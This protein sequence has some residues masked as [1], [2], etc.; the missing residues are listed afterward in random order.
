MV[1]TADP[2]L[3]AMLDA[4]WPAQDVCWQAFERASRAMEELYAEP[5]DLLLVDECLPD[6][7]GLELAMAVKSENVYRQMPVVL[8]LRGPEALDSLDWSAMEVDEFLLRPFSPVEIRSRLALALARAT[9]TLDANP[10]SKLPGN[11]S[12]IQRVQHLVEAGAE[13]GLAY[14]DLDNFKSFNDKYGFSRGD[15]ALMMTA[16]LLV[17]V[18]REHPQQAPAMH[19]VGHVGGDDFVFI[20]PATQVEAACRAVC[21]RFDAIVPS[22]Y[23]E[24]D[25]R[26]GGIRSTDRQGNAQDFPLMSLSIAVVLNHNAKL[27]HAGEAAS[28]A[29]ALKKKAKAISGSSYVMDQRQR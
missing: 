1:I 13:F 15:E 8:V 7:S 25:R 22:F 2:A 23:D 3:T 28:M 18:V 5:P 17:N 27:T 6:M 29:A 16:R 9:R 26:R 21:A 14:V 12:I 19:F 10:L 24:D 11:T 20:L 4:L